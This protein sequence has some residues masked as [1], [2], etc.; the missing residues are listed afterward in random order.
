MTSNEK[1]DRRSVLTALGSAGLGLAAGGSALVYGWDGGDN[2]LNGILP[3]FSDEARKT[4]SSITNAPGYSGQIPAATVGDLMHLEGKDIDGLMIGLLPLARTYARPP[5]SKFFVGAVARG[6]SGNLYFGGN[7]EFAGMSLGYTVHSE[8]AALSN[9]YMHYDT[10]V[11]AIAV[12]AVPCGHCRQFMSEL[13]LD[14]QM[15]ILL[16]GKSPVK[17]SSLLPMGFGPK[18]MGFKD[19]AFPVKDVDLALPDATSDELLREASAA[20]R[21]SYAR[22]SGAPAGIA[23]ETKEGRIFKGS[24]MESAAFNP[25]LS[26]LQIA[27]VG[28]I[29]AGEDYAAIRRVALA[30]VKDAKISQREVTE[31]VLRGIAPGIQLQVSSITRRS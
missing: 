8:Q 25:S 2:S 21:K 30:E 9:V 29:V 11:S 4:L 1:I 13:S 26:P 14:G 5:I 28:M 16:E 18:D 15:E 27:L 17:L 12:T 31:A 22:Y 20:A 24:Y 10:G 7:V 19:G 23:L 3:N 6:A